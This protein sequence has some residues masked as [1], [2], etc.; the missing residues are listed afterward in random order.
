MMT[1]GVVWGSIWL[2][3]GVGVMFGGLA[4]AQ[5]RQ[6]GDGV[7]SEVQALRGADVYGNACA[8][9]H[10][11]DLRGEGFAPA[12]NGD[13]FALRWE[14]EALG[15]LFII[16]QGTMP[17]DAPGELTAGQYAD[18]IAFMLKANGYPAGIALSEKPADSALVGFARQ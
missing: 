8:S 18:V 17:A 13:A 4:H 11:A 1:R 12:L 14:G 6:A 16:V 3:L 2:M 9:C 15:D 5:E 10:M 7:Y